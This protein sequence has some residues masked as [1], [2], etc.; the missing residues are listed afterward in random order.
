MLL[1][2]EY[3]I[4]VETQSSISTFALVLFR[5]IYNMVVRGENHPLKAKVF[6][7]DACQMIM[8]G[9][10]TLSDSEMFFFTNL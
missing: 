4:L 1:E 7:P 8:S 2:Y 6:L 10:G 3:T 9:A 5:H